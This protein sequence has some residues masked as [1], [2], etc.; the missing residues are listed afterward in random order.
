MKRTVGIC[1]VF[2]LVTVCVLTPS[3]VRAGDVVF[4]LSAG[5]GRVPSDDWRIAETGLSTNQ[6]EVVSYSSEWLSPFLEASVAYV[7]RDRWAI[8]LSVEHITAEA[9][10]G[11]AFGVDNAPSAGTSLV[12]WNFSTIPITLSYEACLLGYDRF[13][14]F[15]GLGG[16]YYFS[17]VEWRRLLENPFLEPMESEDTRDGSGA[18]AHCYF[19][20]RAVAGQHLAF[21]SKIRF[22]YADSM[23]FTDGADAF[24]LAFTGFDVS[25]GV[26]VRP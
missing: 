4:G 19:G 12:H 21:N 16:G 3:L 7:F 13:S 25:F 17:T 2:L 18:G 24:S 11:V 6:V 9:T 5:G 1:A 26:E 8:R 15:I 23:G 20:F 14:P 10:T 22:R